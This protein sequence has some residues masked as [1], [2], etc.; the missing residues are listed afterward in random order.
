M[1]HATQSRV[2]FYGLLLWPGT[3][4]DEVPPWADSP[5]NKVLPACPVPHEVASIFMACSC[6][7]RAWGMKSY[8]G[9]KAEKVKSCLRVPCHTRSRLFLWPVPVAGEPGG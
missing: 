8:P 6:G 9:L 4:G 7:R 2:Y 1:S 3:L 5:E